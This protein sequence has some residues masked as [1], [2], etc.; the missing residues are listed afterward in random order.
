M[1]KSLPRIQSKNKCLKNL[2]IRKM[3][4]IQDLSKQ[5]DFNNLIY[6]YKCINYPKAFI[7]FTG[8][9]DF[10]KNMKEVS[11]TLKKAEEEKN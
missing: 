9:L 8:P 6:R 11:T 10:Y 5:N 3:K 7:D 2:L 4:E 1:K